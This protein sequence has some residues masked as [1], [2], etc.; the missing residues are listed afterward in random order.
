MSRKHNGVGF[1]PPPLGP[2]RGID[3]IARAIA[4]LGQ[5]D[6]AKV[7]AVV[8]RL[9]HAL[10]ESN[11][12]FG[13]LSRLV[14]K[15]ARPDLMRSFEDWQAMAAWCH[16]RKDKVAA[17]HHGIIEGVMEMARHRRYEP[18]LRQMEYLW[19]VMKKIRRALSDEMVPAQHETWR[20]YFCG[21]ICWWTGWRTVEE[22]LAH[23]DQEEPEIGSEGDED[24]FTLTHV[25]TEN[26]RMVLKQ[27]ATIFAA[28]RRVGWADDNVSGPYIAPLPPFNSEIGGGPAP[29]MI[30]W[31]Q[32]ENGSSF[33][34]SPLPF[35]YLEAD[36]DVTKIPILPEDEIHGDAGNMPDVV[37]T[38]VPSR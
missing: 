38:V 10:A 11:M 14:R 26:R 35:P 36:R 8:G 20:I 30:G 25:P 18:S 28:M 16:A 33:I 7:V 27:V 34:A 17:E 6:D 22:F 1:E 2:D 15:G 5:D 4:A 3:R 21:Q 37:H 13:D 29:F 24:D 9:A 23:A 12:S 31:N 19:G 32:G